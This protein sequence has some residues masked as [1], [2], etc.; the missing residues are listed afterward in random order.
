MLSPFYDWPESA[1][2]V[3][4]VVWFSG[5]ALVVLADLSTLMSTS[6]PTLDG[7]PDELM[8]GCGEAGLG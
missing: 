6:P 5:L 4:S 8:G 2:L 1:R 3:S 7:S